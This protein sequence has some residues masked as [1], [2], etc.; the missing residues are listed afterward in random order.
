[1]KVTSLKEGMMLSVSTESERPIVRRHTPDRIQFIPDIFAMAAFRDI[2]PL[3]YRSYYMYIG[4]KIINIPED[5]RAEFRGKKTY[6]FHE[7]MDESGM[8]YKMHGRFFKYFEPTWRENDEN[9]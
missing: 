5:M 4:K 6:S 8:V 9:L 2:Y 7:L 3:N 1:M